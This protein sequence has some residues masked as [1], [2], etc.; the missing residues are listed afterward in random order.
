M[1]IDFND[2]FPLY[3]NL[4]ELQINKTNCFAPISKLELEL[5]T[6]VKKLATTDVLQKI[7][8]SGIQWDVDNNYQD[9]LLD[10]IK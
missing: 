7:E 4:K 10:L 2:S 1:K 9:T 8:K 5:A 6:F 3:E